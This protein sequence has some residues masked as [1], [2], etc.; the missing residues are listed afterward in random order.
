MV[1]KESL[2]RLWRVGAGSLGGVA[3]SRSGIQKGFSDS[4]VG[5]R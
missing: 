5:G 2:N 1:E 4:P 3:R